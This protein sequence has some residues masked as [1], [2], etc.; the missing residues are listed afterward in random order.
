MRTTSKSIDH[1]QG[2]VELAVVVG[3][4]GR[5][6]RGACPLSLSANTQSSFLS[7]PSVYTYTFTE[8]TTS[9]TD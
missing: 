7:P 1:S 5:T 4:K 3:S 8:S 6:R 2:S 9:P